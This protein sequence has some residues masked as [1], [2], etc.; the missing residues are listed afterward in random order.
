MSRHQ[1]DPEVVL[2]SPAGQ[3]GDVRTGT[4]G[5][6]PLCVPPTSAGGVR[7]ARSPCPHITAATERGASRIEREE[8]GCYR[9]SP[10]RWP[11]EFLSERRRQILGIPA[12]FKE[13]PAREEPADPALG[14]P[15]GGPPF[16]LRRHRRRI[17][18]T[19]TVAGGERLD[20]RPEN[21]R[22]THPT[23]AEE[24]PVLGGR[25]LVATAG[26]AKAE[27]LSEGQLEQKQTGQGHPDPLHHAVDC[28][29]KSFFVHGVLHVTQCYDT[30]LHSTKHCKGGDR[31][32]LT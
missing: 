27:P 28:R 5:R 15:G 8:W 13:I 4:R 6:G 29:L 22:L 30:L 14:A 31:E 16:L 3:A 2:T 25:D 19:H 10:K 7:T 26:L 18:P 11:L 23:R 20:V 32:K 17:V 24:T 21:P 1:R 9:V 12:G